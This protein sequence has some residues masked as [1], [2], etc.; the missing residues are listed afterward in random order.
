MAL[1]LKSILLLVAP[2]LTYTADEIV[3]YM[4]SVI[5]GS[6]EDIFDFVYE[7]VPSGESGFD[8]A[9]MMSAREKFYE[10]VDGLKK[11]KV[12]KNTL[13][14]TISTASQ[15]L[16]NLDATAAEDWFM[17]STISNFDIKEEMGKF[18][19]N[20]DMFV[21]QKAELAKCPRCWKHHSQDEESTCPRCS[22]VLNA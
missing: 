14:L 1:M 19:V 3:E 5:K 16:L 8:A 17:V 15:T 9:Y 11:E 13:E 12:I 18:E 7:E 2:I 21:I 4:P 6:N 22:K 20:G 10:I